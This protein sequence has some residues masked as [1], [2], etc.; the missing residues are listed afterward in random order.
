MGDSIGHLNVSAGTLGGFAQAQSDGTKV[1][2]SNNHVLADENRAKI[3]DAV[4]QPGSWDNGRVPDDVIGSV[5]SYVPLKR[6]GVNR[7]DIAS[8]VIKKGIEFDPCKV[9]PKR[10]LMGIGPEVLDQATV[11]KYGRTSGA[12]LGRVKS[13]EQDRVWIDYDMGPSAGSI[14]SLRFDNLIEIEGLGDEPFSE[15]GDSGSLI[16]DEKGYAIAMLF[17]GGDIGGTNGKGLTYAFPL[18]GALRRMKVELIH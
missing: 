13:V 18:Q 11:Y 8:A 9:G 4:L 7:Y 2:V 16:L 1:I 15:P 5:W 17:A 12:T 10:K 6:H 3:G 14:V